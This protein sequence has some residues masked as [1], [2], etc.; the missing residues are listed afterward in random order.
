MSH[1]KTKNDSLLS[2]KAI[3][4][5]M[6]IGCQ[7][8]GIDDYQ[9]PTPHTY[10]HVHVH[11]GATWV[12][13]YHGND[14]PGKVVQNGLSPFDLFLDGKVSLYHL[15]QH[16]RLLTTATLLRGREGGGERERERE[17]EY[18]VI[19][20]WTTLH[21]GA[22]KINFTS[23]HIKQ[24]ESVDFGWVKPPLWVHSALDPLTTPYTVTPQAGD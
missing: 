21:C 12:G 8:I 6:I 10:L 1:Q 5:T 3:S 2:T 24:I 7:R 22:L 20:N 4:E 17:R 19:S 16:S 18:I 23:S 13:C 15:I 14:V 9:G 11:V